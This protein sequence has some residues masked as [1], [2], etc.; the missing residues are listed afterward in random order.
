MKQVL[1]QGFSIVELVIVMVIIGILIAIAVP[2]FA[3]L[4]PTAE[5]KTTDSV[6]QALNVASAA[7]YHFSKTGSPKKVTVN[8]CQDIEN[9]LSGSYHGL[10]SGY[11]I[12]SEAITAASIICTVTDS[13]GSGTTADFLGWQVD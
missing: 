12:T 5:Q 7:N 2:R 4:T 11:V 3:D 1:Q 13:S 9:A 8:N 10:P 6:A